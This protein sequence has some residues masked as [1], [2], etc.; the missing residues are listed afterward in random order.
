MML[1]STTN[2]AHSIG[3]IISFLE[4]YNTNKKSLDIGISEVVINKMPYLYQLIEL[5]IPKN[6]IVIL[7]NNKLYNCSKLTMRRNHHFVFLNNWDMIPFT[8]ENTY[9]KFN[10]IQYIKDMFSIN[11]NLLFLKTVE[12]YNEHK[13]KYKLNDSIMLVKT[14]SEKYSVSL[15]RSIEYPNN[16]ILKIIN[17]NNIKFIE[18]GQFEDIYEYIC[19]IYHAKNIIFSYGGPMCTNRFFCSPNANIIVLGNLHYKFEYNYDNESKKY[20][21]LRHAMLSPVKSQHFLLDF[22]NYFSIENINKV[23]SLLD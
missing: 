14:S 6:K 8:I 13:Y 9:L 16:D 18:V 21:H 20:W 15:H 23:I 22:E 2:T 4:Y 7:E 11:C 17:D 5:F 3:E 12:I 1:I 10:N 19:T